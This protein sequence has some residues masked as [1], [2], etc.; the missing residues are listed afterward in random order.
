MFFKSTSAVL[1]SALLL[2]VAVS[3][4]AC[5]R[6]DERISDILIDCQDA[7]CVAEVRS[8]SSQPEIFVGGTHTCALYPSGDVRCWGYAGMGQLGYGNTEQIGDDEDP[9][10]VGFVD[11]GVVGHRIGDLLAQFGQLVEAGQ[12]SDAAIQVD[13]QTHVGNVVG[14]QIRFARQVHVDFDRQFGRHL[15]GVANRVFQKLTIIFVADR[16]DMTALLGT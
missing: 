1:R 14:R 12:A 4:A 7:E 3:A 5:D 15:L 10:S 2:S 11:V 6:G 8:G 16:R 9:S 13:L